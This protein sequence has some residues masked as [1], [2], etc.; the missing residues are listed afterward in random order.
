MR[1][2]C[3]WSWRVPQASGCVL[4]DGGPLSVP[5]LR[6]LVG[7]SLPARVRDD[8]LVGHGLQR[9]VYD[10]H[11]QWL[12]RGQIPQGSCQERGQKKEHVVKRSKTKLQKW[13]RVL[14]SRSRSK[15]SDP[16]RSLS[17]S[18][19]L[20][21]KEEERR[22]SKAE[23]PWIHVSFNTTRI[24]GSE[25]ELVPH[26]HKR[27]TKHKRHPSRYKEQ[28]KR[29]ESSVWAFGT[30]KHSAQTLDTR[31]AFL[32]YSQNLKESWTTLRGPGN[33]GSAVFARNTQTSLFHFVN[34]SPPP[35]SSWIHILR[36]CSESKN[37]TSQKPLR[38]L[39]ALSF[40]NE[41]NKSYLWW[42]H[43]YAYIYKRCPTQHRCRD[44]ITHITWSQE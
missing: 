44:D 2:A 41:S 5:G 23:L 42:P 4:E 22:K 38:W 13:W 30:T 21:H 9:V 10:H 18:P 28:M 35:Q 29:V 11:L 33:S 25:L 3:E 19:W 24:I 32:F 40:R 27:N 6:V 15:L 31:V 1:T 39:S 36:N 14:K 37:N 12:V 43:L 17:L 8:H 16:L 26:D 7:L 20:L 34:I